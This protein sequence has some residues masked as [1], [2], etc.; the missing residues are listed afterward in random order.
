MGFAAHDRARLCW[1]ADA[2]TIQTT[3]LV[4]E[5]FLGAAQPTGPGLARHNP[6]G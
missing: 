4:G 2:R 3:V 6:Q 1:L 5:N